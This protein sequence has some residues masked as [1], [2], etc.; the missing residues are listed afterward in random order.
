MSKNPTLRFST[1][2]LDCS[3]WRVTR[4]KVERAIL[5]D[6]LWDTELPGTRTVRLLTFVYHPNGVLYGAY[7]FCFDVIDGRVDEASLRNACYTHKMQRPSLRRD[8][9]DRHER[10]ALA[11]LA[12]QMAKLPQARESRRGRWILRTDV[13][14]R[15]AELLDVP[16]KSLPL[17]RYGGPLLVARSSRI[18]LSTA[19]EWWASDMRRHDKS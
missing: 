11:A 4:K 15:L 6:G 9:D 2:D 10:A 14:R 17:I 8:D 3:L 1:I 13:S 16:Y 18:S 12:A 5:G 19:I 7:F